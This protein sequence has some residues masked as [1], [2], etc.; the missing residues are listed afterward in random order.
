MLEKVKEERNLI[1]LM[2]F[3]SHLYGTDTPE[4]DTDYLGVY[5]PTKREILLGT[6]QKAVTYNT[7]TDQ[8]KNTKDD[9]DIKLFSLH[10]FIHMAC[11]GEME[12][13][14][15]LHAPLAWCDVTSSIWKDL[16]FKR[17]KFYTKS[18]KAFVGYCR[19][20][21]AK[22]G[23][24]GS[25]IE[26]AEQVIERFKLGLS[27]GRVK[28]YQCWDM[29]P[30]E[31]EHIKEVESSPNDIRQ[32]QVCGRTIQASQ[33]LGY[34]IRMLEG[35]VKKYGHRA[36]LAKENKGI[37]WKAV[38]H[39]CRAGEQLIQIYEEGDI[40]FPLKHAGLLRRIKNGKMDYTTMVA[41]YLEW[42]IDRVE[43]LA[44]ASRYPE[45][46]DREYWQSILAFWVED[47]VGFATA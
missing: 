36:Q 2:K 27:H 15:M 44:K 43:E 32:F 47:N 30:F 39:A 20:Q 46:V 40:I 42:C 13:I 33:K 29:I 31:N 4:S 16:H 38:S 6:W 17:D 34:T 3:G 24:K 45:E 37:D 28:V 35:F 23:I 19:K 7:K 10:R 25:R 9:V 8:D 22:Y 5:L 1:V 41:P 14:D 18:L 11:N 26:A 12:A 21:A